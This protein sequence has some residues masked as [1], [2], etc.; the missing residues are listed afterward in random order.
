MRY[1]ATW[2]CSVRFSPLINF[3]ILGL[4]NLSLGTYFRSKREQRIERNCTLC[5]P[6]ESGLYILC[7]INLKTFGGDPT[8]LIALIK[9]IKITL[10]RENG[11]QCSPFSSRK[12]R[13]NAN[14]CALERLWLCPSSK[15]LWMGRLSFLQSSSFNGYRESEVLS[16]IWTRTDSQNWLS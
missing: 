14:N 12:T 9:E 16:P 4:R 6:K 8:F 13:M 3:S 10:D 5:H 11:G 7:R 2:L 1:I 15:I